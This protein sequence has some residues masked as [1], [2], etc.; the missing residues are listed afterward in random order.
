MINGSNIRRAKA[1]ILYTNI[2]CNVWKIGERW[3][4]SN[5]KRR[6][7]IVSKFNRL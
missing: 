6:K 3:L 7:E 1:I 2:A 4:R 5:G